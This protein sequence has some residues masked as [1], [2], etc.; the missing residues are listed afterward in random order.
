MN[1]RLPCSLLRYSP[2][3]RNLYELH[4]DG[5]VWKSTGAAF[6]GDSCPRRMQLDRNR[7]TTE[8]VAEVGQLYKLHGLR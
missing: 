4:S 8:I 5:S 2:M 3:N 1:A 7:A 6:T